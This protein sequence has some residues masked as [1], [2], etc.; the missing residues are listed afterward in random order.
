MNVPIEPEPINI[1]NVPIGSN[2]VQISASQ[3]QEEF[4]SMMTEVKAISEE[5]QRL[6][7]L[8]LDAVEYMQ[9][10]DY[11]SAHA[12]LEDILPFNL[13]VNDKLRDISK[14]SGIEFDDASYLTLNTYMSLLEAKVQLGQFEGIDGQVQEAEKV[15][16]QA[17]TDEQQIHFNI[18]IA[19]IKSG[20]KGFQEYMEQLDIG[21]HYFSEN[22]N[23]RSFYTYLLDQV[24]LYLWLSDIERAWKTLQLAETMD[25][26]VM[27]Q[28]TRSLDQ[29][30]ADADALFLQPEYQL[31]PVPDIGF[32]MTM[33]LEE[34]NQY[35]ESLRLHNTETT[36]LLQE[37][38]ESLKH[39]ADSVRLWSFYCDNQYR[40]QMYRVRISFARDDYKN[41]L[42]ISRA[43]LENPYLQDSFIQEDTQFYIGLMEALIFLKGDP[44]DSEACLARLN[45]LGSGKPYEHRTMFIILAKAKAFIS[46]HSYAKAY[47]L[48]NA[49]FHDFPPLN[50]TGYITLKTLLAEAA[51]KSKKPEIALLAYTEALQ[52]I[53]AG[54]KTPL[55]YRLVSSWQQGYQKQI[56]A[57]MMLCVS[58]DKPMEFL[59]L[60]EHFK[61][62]SLTTILQSRSMGST[63]CSAD[64]SLA[65]QFDQVN[66][67]LDFLDLADFGGK[68]EE[69]ALEYSKKRKAE[70][71]AT[72][73]EL[74]E[75]IRIADPRW[76][77]ITEMTPLHVPSLQA[78]LLEKNQAVLA[79][80]ICNDQC[81]TVLI[82]GNT[83][84]IGSVDIQS[85][86]FLMQCYIENLSLMDPVT[87]YYDLSQSLGI[88]ITDLIPS[89]L[90]EKALLAQS[91]VISPHRF[92]H[93]L[94]W[95]TLVYK[96]DMIS[97][98]LFEFL[99]VSVVPNVSV[100]QNLR[101]TSNRNV[102]ASFFGVP[103]YRSLSRL[104]PLLK[105]QE[106]IT[107]LQKMYKKAKCLLEPIYSG[108]EA[109]DVALIRSLQQTGR[110]DAILHIVCHGTISPDD[111]MHSA[112][113]LTDSI[114]DASE[115]SQISP[116]AQEVI[117][118]ACSTGYRPIAVQDLE[119]VSDEVLGLPGAFLEAGTKTLLTSISP[120]NDA[121]AVR[122]MLLYHQFR[123]QGDMPM[124]AYQSV[125]CALLEDKDLPPYKWTGFTLYGCE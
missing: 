118:S 29:I 81:I 111:P 107:L 73:R 32:L 14:R 86:R 50:I 24:D 87:P 124:Y 36:R 84:D 1:G 35:A 47:S 109:N 112:L 55:G 42:L 95:S 69:S 38:A 9:H 66:R 88:T 76:R 51:E 85:K 79:M 71:M 53:V 74:Q 16:K 17:C 98:R 11:I 25:I 45:A 39:E 105:G 80:Y 102:K 114:L 43:M 97:K 56:H 8:F 108:K 101:R 2:I 63:S 91:L 34:R 68:T 99:P 27:I 113:I 103:D 28:P 13:A 10:F 59:Q 18:S 77:Q 82:T 78:S 33:T 75:K 93:L 52:A 22:K 37:Q 60:S 44:P 64:I 123:L 12:I 110:T 54:M 30:S 92:L 62:K 106:E 31:A 70:L 65:D 7:R 96:K 115:I 57:A 72:R 61:A 58:L 48:L 26:P 19:K 90:I 83:L 46:K 40:L 21:L 3:S 89:F 122:F 41:T 15:A 100:L 6:H 23:D 121:V 104:S 49:R 4:S 119:I 117:L 67:Q 5:K 125:Q 94:P 20:Y 120:A 116:C